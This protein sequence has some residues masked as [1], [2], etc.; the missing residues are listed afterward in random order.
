MP[1]GFPSTP[2]VG[3]QHPSGS[4]V[5]EWDGAKWVAISGT[6][7]GATQVTARLTSLTNTDDFLALRVV[8]GETTP[9]LVAASVL[10]DFAGGA[11]AATEPA[12][13]TAG[14]WTAT[15]T[16]N[17][18]EISFNLTALPSDGG[19]A[20]TALEYRV[21]TGSAIAF[22]GT[23]TGVRVVTAGL[24]AGAAADLQVRAVNAVGAGAWSDIKNR[25][26]AASGGGGSITVSQ[27]TGSGLDLGESVTYRNG[28]GTGAGYWEPGTGTA[29]MLW[30]PG[31]GF[32]TTN[33]PGTI[34]AA[35]LRIYM[36]EQFGASTVTAYNN[37]RAWAEW[38]GGPN[39]TE[40]A[41][42]SAWATA[43]GSGAADRSASSIGTANA[44]ATNGVWVQITLDA[45]TVEA[46]RQAGGAGACGVQL[47][48]NDQY[49]TFITDVGTDGQRPEL[50]V[51]YS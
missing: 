32:N 10:A 5:W 25:T 20:I 19:S 36:S 35:T 29:R 42:G 9:Y 11:P 30:R 47:V 2:T 43:G 22:T 6:M 14:M 7:S 50:V 15:A 40:W 12:A 46:W 24:T 23:S 44:P 13:F 48:G 37:L 16:A 41:N 39:W 33:I 21:G 51:T 45:A 18:G 4:P 27:N 1:I 28:G 26:P 31:S 38:G 3:Q 34:T 8:S 49:S 17:P